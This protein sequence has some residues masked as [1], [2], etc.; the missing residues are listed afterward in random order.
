MN[1]SIKVERRTNKGIWSALLALAK[2]RDPRVKVGF[3]SGKAGG[4]IIERAI[5]NEFGTRHIRERPF[6]RNAM[7][8]NRSKYADGMR[9]EAKAMLLGS[10]S[11]TS[12]L[13]KLGIVAAGDIQDEITALSSPPNAPSTIRQKGSSNPLIDTGAMRQAVTWKVET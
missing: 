10:T 1:L 3:P 2:A 11:M 7:R 12:S 13:N 6:I 4:A 5:Y 8:G 9:K